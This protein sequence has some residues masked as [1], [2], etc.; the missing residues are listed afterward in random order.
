MLDDNLRPIPQTD[1]DY[2][3]LP[4]N[5]TPEEYFLLSR[6][7]GNVTIGEICQIS[8][9]S[10]DATHKALARL[11]E[12]GLI[13]IPEPEK[14]TAAESGMY[15]AV[16]GVDFGQEEVD[17]PPT[18]EG[19]DIDEGAVPEQKEPA[20]APEHRPPPKVEV[21]GTSMLNPAP[22]LDVDE[23]LGPA[24]FEG[25]P[26]AFSSYAFDSAALS[27]SVEIDNELKR[28]IL[29][30]HAHTAHVDH[31]QMLGVASDAD[32]KEIKKAYFK[33]SKIF[34][35]DSF[36]GKETGSYA[37]RIEDIFGALTKA[38]QVISHKK[39]RAEYDEALAARQRPA[40][41]S[42]QQSAASSSKPSSGGGDSA[43]QSSQ[44]DK[45]K[46]MAFG[47]LV[48]RGEKAEA[49]GDYVDAAEEYKKAFAIKHDPLVAL[50]GAN[51]LMRSGEEH[52]DGAILLAKAAAKEDPE[53]AKP[54]ILIGDAY[55]EKGDYQA[56]RD[57]YER[58]RAVEPD[59]KIVGRRLKYLDT[60]AQ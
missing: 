5:P 7:D 26:A 9:L 27:E 60:A 13:K 19:G 11:Q 25:W 15:G 1:V 53:N 38:H 33:L 51:L 22:E 59:N 2:T 8:G 47:V 16:D 14:K 10:V 28:Y 46:E 50:R 23:G 18:P 49:A 4:I 6:I 44:G 56:A 55:E 12:A 39:K 54:L 58:A 42:A 57:Y 17:T 21:M 30:I 24:F 41:A 36:Y 20:K 43:K 31:Y 48:K 3:S 35:P 45:K 34:H 29:F 52:I 40:A 37:E 32:R